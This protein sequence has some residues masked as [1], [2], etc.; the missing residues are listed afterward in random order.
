[1]KKI[2]T[3]LVMLVAFSL[4]AQTY[5]TTTSSSSGSNADITHLGTL[6]IGKNNPGYIPNPW[7]SY[8]SLLLGLDNQD[9]D[10]AFQMKNLT[11]DLFKKN[12]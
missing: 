7:M 8:N 4:N 1:M 10:V 12:L 2:V 6:M 3:L 11:S 5:F 9:K